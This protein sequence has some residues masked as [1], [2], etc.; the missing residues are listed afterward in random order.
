MK[1]ALERKKEGHTSRKGQTG[2][3]EGSGA[4]GMGMALMVVV[5]E[6]MYMSK[7]A[8][9]VVRAAPAIAKGTTGIEPAGRAKKATAMMPKAYGK[10]G[11]R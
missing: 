2:R 5:Q 7:G 9:L 1:V 8:L 3:E 6:L 10:V 4:R 11:D